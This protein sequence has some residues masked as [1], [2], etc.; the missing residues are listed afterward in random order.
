[1]TYSTEGVVE[2]VEDTLA[3][4]SVLLP[5][6]GRHQN[7]VVWNPTQT[8]Q[9]MSDGFL[10]LKRSGPTCHGKLYFIFANGRKNTFV[11]TE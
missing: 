4:P 7:W 1:M 9:Q 6:R 5:I 11:G 10:H 2:E 3:V 8:P